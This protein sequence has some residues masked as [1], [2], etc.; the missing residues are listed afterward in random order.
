MRHETRREFLRHTSLGASLVCSLVGGWHD[1]LHA[2]ARS[3]TR[4]DLVAPYSTCGNAA[5][6]VTH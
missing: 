1:L 6:T 5:L 3:T 4:Y 2:Q